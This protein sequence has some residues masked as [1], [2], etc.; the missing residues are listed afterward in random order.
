MNSEFEQILFGSMCG[1]G[2]IGIAPKHKTPHYS[3]GHCIA[4]KDYLLWKMKYFM[5]YNPKFYQVSGGKTH[6]L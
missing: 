2:Y 1:D 6:A 4:Q 3:E 5:S